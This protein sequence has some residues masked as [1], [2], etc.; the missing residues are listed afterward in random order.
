MWLYDA[1]YVVPSRPVFLKTHGQS[2]SALTEVL[3]WPWSCSLSANNLQWCLWMSHCE[4]PSGDR[5]NRVVLHIQGESFQPITQIK[6]HKINTDMASMI[7]YS[8]WTQGSFSNKFIVEILTIKNHHQPA[9][10]LST[11]LTAPSK[12]GWRLQHM[13]IQVTSQ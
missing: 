1:L 6:M 10:W 3:E 8:S 2:H 5:A 9:P 7:T 13:F 12:M 4:A 11:L